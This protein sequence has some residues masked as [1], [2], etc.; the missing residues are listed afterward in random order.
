MTYRQKLVMPMGWA[1]QTR[2]FTRCLLHL[3]YG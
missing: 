2:P 1:L 3:S